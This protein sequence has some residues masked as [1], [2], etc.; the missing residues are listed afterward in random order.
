MSIT[1]TVSQD[2]AFAARWRQWE[3][4]NAKSSRRGEIQARVAFVVV[5][6]LTL[7]WLSLR[8]L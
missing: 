7:A 5:L 4:E 2:D 8:L 1:T 3:I 6:T